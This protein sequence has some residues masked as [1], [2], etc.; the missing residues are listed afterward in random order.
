MPATCCRALFAQLAAHLAPAA[1]TSTGAS[2]GDA[3]RVL[4]SDVLPHGLLTRYECR[5]GF[6]ALEVVN[7]MSDN[8]HLFWT[9]AGICCFSP[10][11]LALDPDLF[12]PLQHQ[13]LRFSPAMEQWWPHATAFCWHRTKWMQRHE[14]KKTPLADRPVL[15]ADFVHVPSQAFINLA[16]L[17]AGPAKRARSPTA[18]AR[19]PA[20]ARTRPA[21]ATAPAPTARAPSPRAT[22][23]VPSAA[24]SPDHSGGADHGPALASK[25]H[26]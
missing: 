20:A 11:A 6:L 9:D 14:E 4:V 23:G 15:P 19:T 10:T 12:G 3:A 25:R 13:R 17:T 18:A 16:K 7:W 26:T 2:S 1:A 22:A 8:G 24:A 5:N 21:A